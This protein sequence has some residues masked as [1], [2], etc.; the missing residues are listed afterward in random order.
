MGYVSLFLA[1]LCAKRSY[2]EE[3]FCISLSIGR[4][5]LSYRWVYLRYKSRL[6]PALSD[7]EHIADKI[8]SHSSSKGAIIYFTKA[9]GGP[10]NNTHF[11]TRTRQYAFLFASTDL[12]SA[13]QPPLDLSLIPS[14]LARFFGG[15][16]NQDGAFG[17]MRAV[18]AHAP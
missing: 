16:H 18:V 10:R 5:K 8:W 12:S 9:A 1:G 13:N 7:Y 11:I 4:L 15:P 14:L 6:G 3:Q 17:V 2:N